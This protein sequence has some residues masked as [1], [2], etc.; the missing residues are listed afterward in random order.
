MYGIQLTITPTDNIA[1]AIA[2]APCGSSASTCVSPTDDLGIILVK[3]V[4]APTFHS[5]TDWSPY[6]NFTVSIPDDLP[7]GIWR[8]NV[9]HFVEIGLVQLVLSLIRWTDANLLV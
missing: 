5:I 8:L 3:S 4:Y 9:A 1:V 7:V 6:E 2:L